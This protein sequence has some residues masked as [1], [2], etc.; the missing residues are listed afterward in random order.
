MEYCE[1]FII[2]AGAAGL[3]AAK[4]AA[5]SG[6]ES[7][8]IAESRAYAGG[9]LPQCAHR[10]FGAGLNGAE[11]SEGLM[12]ELPGNVRLLTGTAVLSLSAEKKA[13]LAGAKGRWE[14][15]F[16]A[17][18]LAAGSYEIPAGALDICGTRPEGVYTAGQMQE[19]VNLRSHVPEGPAVI[20]G[21]GD[22]GLIMAAQL[23]SM[24][25]E[26]SV[27]EREKSFGAMA[28]N[29]KSLDG[30]PIGIYYEN[31]IREIRGE[32]EL[33]GVTLTDGRFLP[34]RTLLIAVGLRPERELCRGLE[35]A[36]WLFLCGNC[37]R[38]HPMIEGVVNEGIITGEEAARYI[39]GRKC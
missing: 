15:S 22:L 10:G 19:M 21:G 28:R 26:V 7:I 39:R 35:D 34:C 11:Y 24:G 29:R 12:A 36:D 18:V 32:R 27:V 5:M 37:A 25:L 20:L 16:D 4:A 14:L 13:L 33:E 8:V 23:A 31:S 30:L 6:V 2:G 9:I 38:I 3:S 1:L 17:A